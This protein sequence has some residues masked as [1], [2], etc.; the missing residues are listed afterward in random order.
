VLIRYDNGRIIDRVDDL[1][2]RLS[3]GLVAAH[4][5]VAEP[6]RRHWHEAAR[7][8]RSRTR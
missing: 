7:S 2:D 4:P 3:G 8:A 6:L 1:N 5:T